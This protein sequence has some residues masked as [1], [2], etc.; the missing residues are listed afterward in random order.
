MGAC[1]PQK[2]APQSMAEG[3]SEG[4]AMG[5]LWCWGWTREPDTQIFA[6]GGSAER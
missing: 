1:P 3:S 6:E 4:L 2:E 5:D